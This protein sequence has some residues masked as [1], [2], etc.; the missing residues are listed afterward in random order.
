MLSAAGLYK[1]MAQYAVTKHKIKELCRQ[2]CWWRKKR[3]QINK[4]RVVWGRQCGLRE[5]V[6]VMGVG[7]QNRVYKSLY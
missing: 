4:G 5:P 6:W 3:I 7:V 2:P 1:L